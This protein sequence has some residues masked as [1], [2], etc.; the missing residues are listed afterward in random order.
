MSA[1]YQVSSDLFDRVSRISYQ[2][3][4]HRAKSTTTVKDFI[5]LS[6]GIIYLLVELADLMLRNTAVFSNSFRCIARIKSA[7]PV[8]FFAIP[9]IVNWE[10][11]KAIWFKNTLSGVSLARWSSN[12][13]TMPRCD[14][15]TE[16]AKICLLISSINNLVSSTFF[17]LHFAIPQPPAADNFV[18]SFGRRYN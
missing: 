11:L 3:S 7:T 2:Y 18:R 12:L 1:M 13:S 4:T 6:P 8:S 5:S 10:P 16:I 14:C 15:K 17:F 9:S